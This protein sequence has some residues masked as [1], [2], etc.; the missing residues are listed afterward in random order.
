MLDAQHDAEQ[1]ARL[2]ARSRPS[3]PGSGAHNR[4]N[5]YIKLSTPSSFESAPPVIMGARQPLGLDGFL[6]RQAITGKSE[7]GDVSVSAPAPGIRCGW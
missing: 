6:Q 2:L 3:V 7:H 5:C 1:V 4:L